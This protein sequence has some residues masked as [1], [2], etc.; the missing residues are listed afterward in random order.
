VSGAGASH[1]TRCRE[2]EASAIAVLCHA[3]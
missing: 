2:G 1:T 3:R